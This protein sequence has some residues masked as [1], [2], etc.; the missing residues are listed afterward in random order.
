MSQR[1]TLKQ[2]VRVLPE[3]T[4]VC[5]WC[6]AFEQRAR[7]AEARAATAERRVAKME[8]EVELT[9]RVWRVETAVKDAAR[10]FADAPDILRRLL[11]EADRRRAT[12]EEALAALEAEVQS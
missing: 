5:G 8:R 4:S 3:G 9:R 1:R 10:L 2:L 11:S 6:D 12:V 7:E